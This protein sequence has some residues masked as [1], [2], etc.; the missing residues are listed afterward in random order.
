MP[1]DEDVKQQEDKSWGEFDSLNSSLNSK[2]VHSIRTHHSQSS[3]PPH[4]ELL[5]ARSEMY[6]VGSE[7]WEEGM[8]VGSPSPAPAVV[9][10]GASLPLWFLPRPVSGGW[11][12][13]D[14]GLDYAV[15]SHMAESLAP[16]FAL[17]HVARDLRA[18][19]SKRVS[20]VCKQESAASTAHSL[21]AGRDVKSYTGGIAVRPQ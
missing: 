18:Q 8:G 11:P 16:L 14:I 4:W 2:C 21:N 10:L 17:H 19:W 6:C 1:L 12:W 5:Y 9:S 13:M 3:P 20:Q 7:G 15:L